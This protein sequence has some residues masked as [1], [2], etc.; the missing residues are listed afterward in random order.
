MEQDC[1]SAMKEWEEEK[2]LL[3]K[4]EFFSEFSPSPPPY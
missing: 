3:N 1:I 4:E 2:C